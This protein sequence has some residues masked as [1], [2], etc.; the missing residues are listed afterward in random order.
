MIRHTL[1]YSPAAV[2]AVW[3]FLIYELG[4]SDNIVI[5]GALALAAALVLHTWQEVRDHT[6]GLL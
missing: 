1:L 3:A 4:R 6:G 5:G 2:C